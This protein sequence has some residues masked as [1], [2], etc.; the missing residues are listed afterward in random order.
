MEKILFVT[1]GKDICG[2]AQIAKIG[3]IYLMFYFE[4]FGNPVLLKDLPAHTV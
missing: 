1:R 2:D 4:A 3:D